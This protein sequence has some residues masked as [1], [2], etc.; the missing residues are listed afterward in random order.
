MMPIALAVVLGLQALV[1]GM[2]IQRK[3]NGQSVFAGQS[4]ICEKVNDSLS[5][6]KLESKPMAAPSNY[7]GPWTPQK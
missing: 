3:V 7:F 4:V 5:D 2:V 1:G 6:C